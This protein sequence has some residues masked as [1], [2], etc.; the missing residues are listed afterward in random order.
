MN[1]SFSDMDK[2]SYRDTNDRA[3]PLPQLP[4]NP[5]TEYYQTSSSPSMSNIPMPKPDSNNKKAPNSVNIPLSVPSPF[6]SSSFSSHLASVARSPSHISTISSCSSSSSCG[7]RSKAEA[8]A[9]KYELKAQEKLAKRESKAQYKCEKSQ[10]DAIKR[11]LKHQAKELKRELSIQ[12]K[13]AVKTAKNEFNNLTREL[14]KNSSTNTTRRY[15]GC[16]HCYRKRGC[17]C[18]GVSNS[19]VQPSYSNQQVSTHSTQGPSS[20]SVYQLAVQHEQAKEQYRQAKKQHKEQKRWSHCERRQRRHFEHHEIQFEHQE[21]Q[22]NHVPFPFS[23]VTLGP[24]IV[25]HVVGGVIGGVQRALSE[26][27]SDQHPNNTVFVTP[28]PLPQAPVYLPQVTSYPPPPHPPPVHSASSQY[29]QQ[30]SVPSAQNGFGEKKVGPQ[31]PMLVYSMSN[32]N[33]NQPIAASAPSAPPVSPIYPAIPIPHTGEDE[34]EDDG[35][36]PPPYEVAAST[37][38]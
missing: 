22:H 24:R 18:F 9:I 2:K 36:A 33:L 26:S 35:L 21:I 12:T 1:T 19:Q 17:G 31:E 34:Q 38:H 30:S 8:K 11:E 6:G 29:P 23:L 14:S 3:R 4:Y 37:R 32:M 16:S 20:S 7:S 10:A 13:E 27:S 25:G 15:S 28:A 5:A